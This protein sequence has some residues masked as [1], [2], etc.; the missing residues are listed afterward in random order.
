MYMYV[1]VRN[2]N[3]IHMV[4]QCEPW[5]YC[6]SLFSFKPHPKNGAEIGLAVYRFVP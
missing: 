3:A 4:L 2:F 6:L 5:D 1:L